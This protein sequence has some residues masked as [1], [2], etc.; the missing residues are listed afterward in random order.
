MAT[1]ESTRPLTLLRTVIALQTLAV[2]AAPV[3]AG[4]LLTTPYGHV[5]HSAASYTIWVVAVLH[6][7]AAVPAWRPGGGSPRPI[8]SAAV[9][10]ALVSAQVALGIAHVTTLHVPLGVLLFGISVLQLA[11]V[12]PLRRPAAA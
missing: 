4:L 7:G 9:F 3:T 8:L 1:L 5:L 6:V 2:F 11:W 12:W 10:L